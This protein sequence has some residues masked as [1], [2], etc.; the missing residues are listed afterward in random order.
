M[1]EKAKIFKYLQDRLSSVSS[2]RDKELKNGLDDLEKHVA[3]TRIFLTAQKKY[4]ATKKTTK[5]L[6]RQ[7]PK[8]PPKDIGTND[9]DESKW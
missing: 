1:D 6:S 3:L 9:L 2:E 4:L 8:A 7:V 5:N